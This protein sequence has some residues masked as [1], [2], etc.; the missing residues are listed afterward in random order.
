MMGTCDEAR[1]TKGERPGT[2]K[3]GDYHVADEV[4]LP[5]NEVED[6]VEELLA[7]L[8]ATMRE[9]NADRNALAMTAYA[10]AAL[11]D[12]HPFADGNGRVARLL[13]NYVLLYLSVPP[14]SVSADDRLA[15]FGALDAFH[16]SGDLESFKTLCRVQTLKTWNELL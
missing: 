5:P 14:I 1:W 4:G 9:S 3:C 11:V 13:M 10:H 8:A 2:S 12:I 15:Y 7:E 16:E 6:A